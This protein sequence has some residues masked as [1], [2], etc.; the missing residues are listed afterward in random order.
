[1]NPKI[2]VP[3][4]AV[5]AYQDPAFRYRFEQALGQHR[6]PERLVAQAEAEGLAALLYRTLA[7]CD[8]LAAL[9]PAVQAGLQDRYRRTLRRNLGLLGELRRILLAAEAAGIRVVL[10]QG[11]DL[12]VRTYADPGLRPVSDIDL[13]VRAEDL[14]VFG[15]ILS[16]LAYRKVP[17]CDL[18][19]QK[20]DTLLD[21]HTDLMGGQRIRSR[22]SLWPADP[23]ET[24]AAAVP[25]DLDGATAWGL[26]PGDNLFYLLHHALKHRLTALKWLADLYFLTAGWQAADWT[27]WDAHWRDAGQ[28]Q[29]GGVLAYLLR[30]CFGGR[31]SCRC[32]ARRCVSNP[33]PWVRYALRPR[34]QGRRLAAWAPM[35][36]LPPA[37]GRAKW[38]LVIETAFP[39]RAILDQ[40]F[41]GGS[42][43]PAWRLYLRRVGQM[44]G[45][46][47]G[48]AA[49]RAAFLWRWPGQ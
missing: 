11:L 21:V 32:A 15:G 27:A 22:R 31:S 37:G 45:R 18:Q 47:L 29:A 38:R 40:M 24:M 6:R 20:G 42:S 12:L 4:L 10:L 25:V 39:R 3:A 34:I 7:R 8:L 2:G 14:P 48:A 28:P 35:V 13:W 43:R 44:G 30:G 41:A 36:V 23:R 16:S 17:P 19:F 26:D 1:M 49:D 46:L 9:P 33:G 5:A